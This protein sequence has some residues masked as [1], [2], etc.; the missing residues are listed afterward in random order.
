M[1]EPFLALA[2]ISKSYGGFKAVDDVSFAIRPGE[3]VGLV[4]ENG[5]GKSTLMKILGGVIAPS[6]GSLVVDGAELA[7]MTVEGAIRAG[8]AFVHQEL[9]AFDTLSVAANVFIGREP[10]RWGPLQAGG[11]GGTR[12]PHRAPARPTRRVLFTLHTDG[13]TSRSPSVS[14]WR[15][16]RPCRCA[17][18]S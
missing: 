12:P 6:E 4:G 5:A 3:V 18:G 13:P 8:I 17:P 1:T 9:N 15:S 11:R 2:R 16:P 14:W 7:R 10:V